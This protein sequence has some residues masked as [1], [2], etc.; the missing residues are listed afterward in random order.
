VSHIAALII[1]FGFVTFNP[2]MQTVEIGIE[3]RE[4]GIETDQ[5]VVDDLPDLAQRMSGRNALLKVD[6]AE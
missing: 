3:R 1:G 6:V 2:I 4:L 5:R